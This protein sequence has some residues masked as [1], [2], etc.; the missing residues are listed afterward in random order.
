[1]MRQRALRSTTHDPATAS[2]LHKIRR[3]TWEDPGGPRC[4]F[5]LQVDL[6]PDGVVASAP[7]AFLDYALPARQAGGGYMGKCTKRRRTGDQT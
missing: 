6:Q 5:A 7:G 2:P 1:M 4:S 3:R